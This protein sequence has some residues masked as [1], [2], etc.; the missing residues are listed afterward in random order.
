M[1]TMLPNSFPLRF[2]LFYVCVCVSFFI[3]KEKEHKVV[4]CFGLPPCYDASHWLS[5]PEPW[6]EHQVYTS[7]AWV[8]SRGTQRRRRGRGKSRYIPYDALVGSSSVADELPSKRRC[9]IGSN[10]F[11]TQ[12]KNLKKVLTKEEANF[13]LIVRNPKSENQVRFF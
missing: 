8:F 6:A 10:F 3:W 5:G 13:L 12:R 1:I 4:F 2:F 7:Q 11:I 9:S